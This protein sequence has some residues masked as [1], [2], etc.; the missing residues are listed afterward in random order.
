MTPKEIINNVRA[1][2]EAGHA[3][4][5]SLGMSEATTLQ[6]CSDIDHLLAIHAAVVEYLNAFRAYEIAM[7]EAVL[8][9]DTDGKMQRAFEA[10]AK[11]H[12]NLAALCGWKAE[13]P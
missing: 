12:A 13:E 8:I 7:M 10:R 9:R 3:H 6:Q 1:N 2:N 11:A 4:C 5:M